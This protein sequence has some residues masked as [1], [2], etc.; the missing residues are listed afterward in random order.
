[1]AN[2]VGVKDAADDTQFIA[3]EEVDG[4]HIPVVAVLREGALFGTATLATALTTGSSS[5]MTIGLGDDQLRP[6]PYQFTAWGT[7]DGSRIKLQFSPNSGT[8]WID[9]D[10]TYVT[11][12]AVIGVHL[13]AGQYRL[14]IEDAGASTSWNADFRGIG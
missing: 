2:N 9:T 3:T 14:T 8:T 12:A 13:A 10:I 5:A 4:V 11:A 1:M 6:G 7:P